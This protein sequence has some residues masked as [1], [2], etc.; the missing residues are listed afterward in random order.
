MRRGVGSLGRG[1][2]VIS[3]RNE[4][5]VVMERS[6]RRMSPWWQMIY[7]MRAYGAAVTL[8]WGISAF[9]I[10][11]VFALA[12]SGPTWLHA[13]FGGAAVGELAF[14]VATFAALR[15]ANRRGRFDV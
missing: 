13:T 8:I 12:L 6:R 4:H 2:G 11:A 9:I 15:R 7:G 14:S 5:T 3:A 10:L 1:V